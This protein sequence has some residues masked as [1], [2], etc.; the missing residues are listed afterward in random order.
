MLNKY[1]SSGQTAS[2]RPNNAQSNR[3]H[4]NP[5]CQN[6]FWREAQRGCV[7]LASH[8]RNGRKSRCMEMTVLQPQSLLQCGKMRRR[9]FDDVAQ[10]LFAFFSALHNFTGGLNLL[11]ML[12]PIRRLVVLLVLGSHGLLSLRGGIPEPLGNV[13]LSGKLCHKFGTN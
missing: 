10:E 11:H 2:W 5:Q 9:G 13:E 12:R 8:G 6:S 3:S 1:Q 4:H 7:K